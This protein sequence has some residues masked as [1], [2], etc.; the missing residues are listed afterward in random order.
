E[1]DERR[2]TGHA[3]SAATVEEMA[4]KYSRFGD[5]Y[6]IFSEFPT[7]DD[8]SINS[9]LTVAEHLDQIPNHYVRGNA[10]GMFDATVGIWQILA[11]QHQI[12][13]SDLNRSFQ[14]VVYQFGKI[15]NSTNVFDA[16]RESLKQLLVACT[17]K[18]DA[19]QEG[20]V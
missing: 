5:Q 14:Q 4:S 11:R 12:P 15:A 7:L 13:R 2:G 16:G 20:I 9:F 8:V 19:S 6:L 17:G 1:L 3:L 10:L 18:A